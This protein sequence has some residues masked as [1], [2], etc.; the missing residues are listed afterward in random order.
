MRS[1][2]WKTYVALAVC[3]GLLYVYYRQA[4]SAGSGDAREKVLTFDRSLAREILLE[5]ADGPA[6]RLVKQADVWRLSQPDVPAGASEVDNLLSSFENLQVDEVVSETAPSSLAPY[7]LDPP[8][9]RLSVWLEGSEHPLR[10]HLGDKTPD[11]S[12]L[13]AQRAGQPQLLLV[14]GHQEGSFDKRPFDLRDRDLL[15]VKRDAVQ[16]VAIETPGASYTLVRGEKN[17]WSFAQP[18]KT[19]AGRWAVDSLLGTLENLRMERV[20]VEDAEDLAPFGLQQP[21]YS[22]VL[23]LS[24]GSRRRLE[25]GNSPEDARY[26]AREASSDLVAVIAGTVVSDLDKG[27]GNLR[28]RRLVD[29]ST[30]DV[31]AFETEYGGARYV[32]E[33]TT[34]KADDGFEVDTWKRTVPDEQERET[35]KIED[36]LFK[37]GGLEVLEFIDAPGDA[38]AYGFDPPALALTLRLKDDKPPISVTVG[39]RNAQAYARRDGDDAVLRLDGPKVSEALAS[40]RAL[41]AVAAADD[42]A[43]A[44]ETDKPAQP[45][46]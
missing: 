44:Q 28:A 22:V 31:I 11:G 19:R 38:T 9:T 17:T 21:A 42:D 26:H 7:G 40:V 45:Q 46:G 4:Q 2:F 12:A 29:A 13:Y 8:R 25:I 3:A 20:A 35:S 23:E 33:S 36:A 34:T 14:P 10:V 41:S 15:H 16:N 24:D 6:V 43:P 37:L 30:F 27:M 5:P 32:Y 1:P 39:R 18:L